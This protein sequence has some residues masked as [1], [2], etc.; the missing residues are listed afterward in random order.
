MVKKRCDYG[1]DTKDRHCLRSARWQCQGFIK[2]EMLYW[3]DKH[4]LEMDEP[5]TKEEQ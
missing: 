4:R 2:G 3:C 1:R 5:I